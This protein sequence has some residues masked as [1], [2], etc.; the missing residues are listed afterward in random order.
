MNEKKSKAWVWVVICAL[1]LV[2]AMV[3]TRTAEYYGDQYNKLQATIDTAGDGG[4]V[5]L[6]QRHENTITALQDNDRKLRADLESARELNRQLRDVNGRAVEIALRSNGRF[7]ELE[8]AMDSGG[9]LIEDLISR[10]QRIDVLVN[11]LREDNR[12]LTD[13]L[14]V[15]P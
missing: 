10:E 3:A 6:I 5:K 9:D 11:G 2:W 8:K 4:L 1:L 15:R 13:T 14:G 7:A 12:R